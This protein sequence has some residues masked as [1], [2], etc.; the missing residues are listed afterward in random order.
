MP[1]VPCA[2]ATDGRG[3]VSGGVRP[4]L[5]SHQLGLRWRGSIHG[6]IWRSWSPC[7]GNARRHGSCC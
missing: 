7:G 2:Q 4:V 5:W 3:R 1:C 6:V